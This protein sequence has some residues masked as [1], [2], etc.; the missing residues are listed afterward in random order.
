MTDHRIGIYRDPA[1]LVAPLAESEPDIADLHVYALE[2]RPY[3]REAELYRALAATRAGVAAAVPAL[4]RLTS[5]LQPAPPDPYLELV[6]ALLHGS[7]LAGAQRALDALTARAPDS[8]SALAWSAVLAARQGRS[9]EAVTL[10]RELVRRFPD[11]PEGQ[12]NLG[13]MLATRGLR[14][15]A[16]PFLTR[17]T[18]LRPNLVPAWAGLAAARHAL[19]DLSGEENALRR[20]IAV[21]PG[22]AE[23]YVRLSAALEDQ[24]RTKEGLELLRFAHTVARHPER[25]ALPPD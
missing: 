12:F 11:Q 10:Q 19:G 5:A 13:Q 9:D 22:E 21:D 3:G 25:I 20:A 14:R 8:P 1:A 2:P 16:I 23:L 6:P 4:E 24:G 7:D 15:E 17:A 18:E